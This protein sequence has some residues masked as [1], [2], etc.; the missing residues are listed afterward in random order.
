M[1]HKLTSLILPTEGGS[2]VCLLTFIIARKVEFM[3]DL[4]GFVSSV[5]RLYLEVVQL[6]SPVDLPISHSL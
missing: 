2:G 4:V 1:R 6:F 3:L 5:V